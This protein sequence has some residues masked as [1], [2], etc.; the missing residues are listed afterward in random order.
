M[1]EPNQYA[2]ATVRPQWRQWALLSSVV[3]ALAGVTILALSVFWDGGLTEPFLLGAVCGLGIV[4]FVGWRTITLSRAT[5]SPEPITLATWVTIGR[6]SALVVLA[7]F[8]FV[9]RPSGPIAWAP[10]ALFAI[11]TTFDALDGYLAR[12]RDAV[13]EL[14]GRLDIEIDSLAVLFGSLLAVRYGIAPAVFLAVG[15]ARYAFVG[16]MYYRRWRDEPV[17]ELDHSDLRRA[18]G[19]LAM[20]A[21]FVALAPVPGLFWSTVVAVAVLVPFL[22]NFTR[23]WLYVSGRHPATSEG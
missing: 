23:D 10:P 4:L 7:G 11:A 3:T 17:Y 15:F 14:G 8:F 19:G 12:A 6:A 16:G 21:I 5:A 18:L 13:S 20:V 2:H 22:L 1:A 9:G